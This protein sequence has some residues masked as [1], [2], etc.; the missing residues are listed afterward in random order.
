MAF[1]YFLFI[2]LLIQSLRVW[3]TSLIL[4][5]ENRVSF[6]LSGFSSPRGGFTE[7]TDAHRHHTLTRTYHIA[8]GRYWSICL[9]FPRRFSC[10][11][12]FI[13]PQRLSRPSFSSYSPTLLCVCTSTLFARA[14]Q[15][16]SVSAAS[17]YTTPCVCRGGKYGQQLPK[18]RHIVPDFSDFDER[19]GGRRGLCLLRRQLARITCDRTSLWPPSLSTA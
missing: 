14:L 5:L 10:S 9:L 13:S 6:N 1:L 19:R 15:V 4:F 2:L 3:E 12:G 7:Q 16:S 18:D 11:F 8:P 17:W